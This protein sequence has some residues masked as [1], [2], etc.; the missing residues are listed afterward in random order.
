MLPNA[1]A[2]RPGA[3]GAGYGIDGSSPGSLKPVC[4]PIFA[5]Q[6]QSFQRLV[7]LAWCLLTTR[8]KDI[9]YPILVSR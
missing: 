2:Q 9:L 5:N 4:S 6:G 7:G 3:E 1:P 8:K